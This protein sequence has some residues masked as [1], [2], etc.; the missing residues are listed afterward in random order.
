MT[1]YRRLRVTWFNR[2]GELAQVTCF[3]GQDAAVQLRM[4]I[5]DAGG[6]LADGD[7]F[8]IEDMGATG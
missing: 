6:E 4:M 1:E 5:A 7:Q 3:N 8:K 2:G